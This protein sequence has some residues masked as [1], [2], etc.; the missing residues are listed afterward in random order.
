MADPI[1]YVVKATGEPA[2]A[3][4]G[5]IPIGFYVDPSAL[6]STAS[7]VDVAEDPSVGIDAGSVQEVLSALAARI[8]ALEDAA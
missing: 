4:R 2:E 3:P 7:S 6:T 5:A 1:P 8:K